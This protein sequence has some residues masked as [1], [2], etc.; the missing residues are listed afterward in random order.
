MLGLGDDH[1]LV[2]HQQ[3][4]AGEA[5]HARLR[6][7]LELDLAPVLQRDRLL[8][9][10]VAVAEDAP[11]LRAL[12]LG[13]QLRA[14]ADDRLEPVEVLGRG[15]ELVRRVDDLPLAELEEAEELAGDED[16]ALAV[17]ARHVDADLAGLP[18]AVGADSDGAGEDEL[19]L[20]IEGEADSS[21]ELD[22]LLA[23]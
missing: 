22:R 19:L 16:L 4:D 13:V 15:L 1:R 23:E 2:E 11:R 5:A 20:G 10:R 9:V 12:D 21:C 6:P 8:A 17:L 3:I 18:L 7:R 14:V